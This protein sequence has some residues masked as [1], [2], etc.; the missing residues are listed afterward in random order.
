M[1]VIEIQHSNSG[2]TACLTNTFSDQNL[3]EQKYHTVLSAAAVSTVNVHSAVMLDDTGRLIKN[4]TYY[5]GTSE[6]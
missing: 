4:E 5:H 1:V 2:E 3:A 6:E